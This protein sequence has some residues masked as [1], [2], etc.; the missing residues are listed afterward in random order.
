MATITSKL[1]LTGTGVS[2]DVLSITASET[3][4]VEEPTVKS[5]SLD[6]TTAKVTL[7]KL[8]GTLNTKTTYV[9]IKNTG[10]S[11]DGDLYVNDASSDVAATGAVVFTG[12]PGADET[13]VII[14]GNLLSK[15]YTAKSATDVA[16]REFIRTGSVTAVAAA[17]KLCIDA[18]AGHLNTIKAT[19]DAGTLNL[20]QLVEGDDG[21]TTI[22]DGLANA[23]ATNFTGG[24]SG[25]A[26]MT[27][28]PGEWATFPASATSKITVNGSAVTTCEYGWWTVQ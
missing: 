6:I 21:N 20:T 17:L 3:L 22:T 11:T 18:T 16:A 19:P 10:S 27:L 2:S 25:T 26:I 12:N 8:D 7:G 28:K 13:V 9:Y 24:I 5:G 4:N 14:D 23:T 15:T 1:T